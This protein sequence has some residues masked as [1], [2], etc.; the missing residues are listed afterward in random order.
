MGAVL[1]ILN[2]CCGVG[3]EDIPQDVHDELVLDCWDIDIDV[4]QAAGDTLKP[5]EQRRKPSIFLN[6]S[7]NEEPVLLF[8]AEEIVIG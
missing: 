8:D 7:D 2:A 5:L 3:V 1:Y 4:S 6:A